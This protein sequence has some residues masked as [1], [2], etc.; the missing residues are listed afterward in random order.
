MVFEKRLVVDCRGHLLGRLAAVI[1]KELLNGQKIVAV[2]CEELDVSGSFYRNKLKYLAFLNK[3]CNVNPR[4]GPFHFRAPS[5][6]LWRTIRGMLPHKTHRGAEAL[7]RLKVFEGV[8]APWDHKKR[9]VVPQALRVVRLRPG[10]KFCNIGKLSASF[11]WKYADIIKTLE[12]KR[13]IKSQRYWQKK[14]SVEAS[15]NQAYKNS[16]DSVKAV[17]S[18]L[19]PLGY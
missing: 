12:A 9:H 14:R 17:N 10:R 1:A 13:K 4:R 8:P 15:V 2:R 11:G 5:K 18:Q 3:K 6:I 19:K 16:K 7:R